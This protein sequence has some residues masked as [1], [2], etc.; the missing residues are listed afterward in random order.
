M[1]TKTPII[2]N[3]VS[4]VAGV[5]LMAAGSQ[6]TFE[7]DSYTVPDKGGATVTVTEVD[8]ET[9]KLDFTIKGSRNESIAGLKQKISEIDAL[10]ARTDPQYIGP[11]E[12][13]R[14][15]IESWLNAAQEVGVEIK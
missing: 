9:I 2:Q 11:L 7:K 5:G 13:E 14:A 8:A 4:F 12:L 15:Q 1:D 3:V 10:I 6:I